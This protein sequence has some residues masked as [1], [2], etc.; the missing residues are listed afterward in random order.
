[1]IAGHRTTSGAPLRD[2]DLLERGNIIIIRKMG[3]EQRW[4]VE[5]SV[6]VP[7]STI[8][9]IRSRPGTRKLVILA[10]NPPFSVEERLVVSARLGQ[11]AA[12]PSTQTL[13]AGPFK[14]GW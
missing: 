12:G 13:R 11:E 1:V 6:I 7:P 14:G 4:V 10:C 8:E 5:D 2:I 3:V 9:I